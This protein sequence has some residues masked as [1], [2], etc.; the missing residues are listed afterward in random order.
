MRNVGRFVVLGLFLTTLAQAQLNK[1]KQGDAVVAIVAANLI[2]GRSDQVQHN[3]LIVIK[4]NRITEVRDA[5][6]ANGGNNAGWVVLPDT[7]TVMPGMIESHTHIF[8]QG[9]DPAK[10]GYDVN[11]LKYPLAYRAA[12]ATVSARRLLE[13]GFTTARDVE[14]EGAGYGD[15]GIRDAINDGW[16]PGPRLF[17]VTKALST[18]GGYPLEGYAPELDL[19]KGAQIAD[20][21]V[22]FRKATREQLGNGA[23]WIKVYMTHRSWVDKD[24]HLQSQPTLTLDEIKAV[25]DEAHGWGKKV[26]CHAYNGIGMRRALDGGCDSIEH[27]LEL[28]DADIAQMVKQ[29]TWYCPT[30]TPYYYW[31]A[32]AD[33]PE[34]KRDRARVAVHGPSFQKALKA[35]VK[36]V[37]GTDAGSFEWTDPNSPI[38]NEFGR[39]V[40]FGMTP[41]QAIKSVTSMPA[42]MLNMESQIG[43]VA[44]GAFADIIAVQGDPLKDVKALKSVSFVV[45]DGKVFKNDVQ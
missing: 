28:T 3:K 40:E 42:V 1:Q 5:S 43:V 2:D 17:V 38:A 27:G 7:V 4:G 16:I 30:L 33:T 25:V 24:G 34:G 12:R 35:G 22:E 26:A 37:F 6:G 10:G 20:G 45:K 18:T 31:W 13:Q 19:P 15:I 36:I 21:P 44:P 39:M 8:L 32:P 11:I 29:G 41:A 9:E 14:T 23:D